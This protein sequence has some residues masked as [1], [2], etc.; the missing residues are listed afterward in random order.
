MFPLFSLSVS[1]LII[2]IPSFMHK[3]NK[4]DDESLRYI[5]EEY[6]L[7]SDRRKYSDNG[8]THFRS[9]CL[10][11]CV[12]IFNSMLNTFLIQI[13]VMKSHCNIPITILL[14]AFFIKI[15]LINESE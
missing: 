3:N 4:P 1:V 12:C 5:K 8:L 10:C 11:V 9:T 7:Q 15:P 13:S 2:Y 14:N 6:Y